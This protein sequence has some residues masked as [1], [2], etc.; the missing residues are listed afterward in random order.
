MNG[1]EKLRKLRAIVENRQHARIDG[2]TVDLLS[3][4]L[5]LQVYDALSLEKQEQYLAMPLERMARIAYRV[6]K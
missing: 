2:I 1:L 3:A 6:S 4:G 5:I